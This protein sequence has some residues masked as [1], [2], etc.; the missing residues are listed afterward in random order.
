MW[1]HRRSTVLILQH[2][3]IIASFVMA[4]RSLIFPHETI[5]WSRHPPYHRLRTPS[6]G[7]FSNVCK[8][9][10][11]NELWGIQDSFLGR[12]YF[13]TLPGQYT[14]FCTK[15]SFFLLLAEKNLESKHY[16]SVVRA[17]HHN[18]ISLGQG[19]DNTDVVFD[20][21]RTERSSKDIQPTN[22]NLSEMCV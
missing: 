18:K 3:A 2:I 7:F 16:A 19:N 17:H 9:F 5:N 21:N 13:L 6:K 12:T 15:Q 4:V 14:I 20:T 22:V 8:M 11:P 10:W 1:H